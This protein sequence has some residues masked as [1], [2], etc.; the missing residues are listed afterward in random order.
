MK[1]TKAWLNWSEV[2]TRVLRS[3]VGGPEEHGRSEDDVGGRV[4][5]WVGDAMSGS[6]VAHEYIRG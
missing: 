5:G 3:R 4:G 6:C 1:F 2:G